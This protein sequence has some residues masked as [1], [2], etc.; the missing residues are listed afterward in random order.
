MAI[1]DGSRE[2][3]TVVTQPDGCEI[4]FPAKE[5]HASKTPVYA[6]DIAPILKENCVNCHRVGGIAPFAMD[7][8]AMV[9]GWSP[10]I[11]E[12]LMTKR[13]PPAQVDPDIK[14]FSN[15]RYI[16]NEELQTLVHWIDAGAPAGDFTTDPLE[17]LTFQEGWELGEPDH[18]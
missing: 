11:R 15:A 16:S 8:H 17:G 12:T 18:G 9:Q 13:M 6:A 4:S 1:A 10:M 14:H 7:S 3:E 2:A 5:M